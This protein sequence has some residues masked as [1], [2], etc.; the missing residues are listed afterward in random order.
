MTEKTITLNENEAVYL[1]SLLKSFVY[2]S[3]PHTVDNQMC[4]FRCQ[5]GKCPCVGVDC[6]DRCSIH[7]YGNEFLDMINSLTKKLES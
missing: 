4:L 3:G 2:G 1:T 7:R 5:A 6:D